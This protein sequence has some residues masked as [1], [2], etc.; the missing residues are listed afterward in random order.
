MRRKMSD[1]ICEKC[2][3]K[4]FVAYALKDDKG[5]LICSQCGEP[6]QQDPTTLKSSFKF[7]QE[8]KPSP[9]D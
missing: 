1:I 6:Y 4:T 7:K 5:R 9:P 2:G 3:Y 8:D